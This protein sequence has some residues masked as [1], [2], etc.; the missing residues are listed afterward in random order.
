V[1]G[2]ARL[3]PGCTLLPRRAA[4][5]GPRQRHR[6]GL[7]VPQPQCPRA[8]GRIHDDADLAL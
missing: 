4:G 3:A 6:A 5:D 2:L 1:H 7:H 8:R